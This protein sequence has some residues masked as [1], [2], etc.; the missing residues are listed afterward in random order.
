MQR[1]EINQAQIDQIKVRLVDANVPVQ[2]YLV[3]VNN[4]SAKPLAP[5]SPTEVPVPACPD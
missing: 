1:Y 2:T 5:P 4:L 3:I